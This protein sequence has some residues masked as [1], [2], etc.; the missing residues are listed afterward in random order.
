MAVAGYNNNVF[1]NCPFDKAYTPLL[2]VIVYTVYRCGFVPQC[3]LAE[4]DATD[5][6]LDKII[7]LVE[8][9]RYGI[10]DISRI[11]LTPA[12]LPRF[13]MPFELGIFFGAKKLG[14]PNQKNKNALVFEKTKFSYQQYISDL[15]GIDTKAHNNDPDTILVQIRNWLATASRRKTIPGYKIILQDYKEFTTKLPGIIQLAGLDMDD[16]P[17]NDYCQVVEEAIRKKV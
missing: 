12:G 3:A 4:D 9:C 17:F 7:R 10:H 11:E 2:Q 15:N 1:V 8:N 14:S 13:N 6:R 5:N 16:I